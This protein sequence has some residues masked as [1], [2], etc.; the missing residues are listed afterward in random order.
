M[1]NYHHLWLFSYICVYVFS[2]FL[3]YLSQ[4]D[5]LLRAHS[6]DRFTILKQFTI[7][8][9]SRPPNTP[10][11]S[12][13][14]LFASP[15]LVFLTRWPLF[16][17]HPKPGHLWEP[18]IPLEADSPRLSI[19]PLKIPSL[20]ILRIFFPFPRPYCVYSA[21]LPLSTQ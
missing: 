12:T 11:L 18:L 13:S 6:Q 17:Y 21:T 14:F 7:I 9:Y 15:I 16:P 5:L 20:S 3:S 4:L 2:T 19:P 1:K 10:L 8:S